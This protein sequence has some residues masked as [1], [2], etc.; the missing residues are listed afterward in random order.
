MEDL[1]DLLNEGRF[2]EA[3]KLAK[4][5]KDDDALRDVADHYAEAGKPDRAYEI[6]KEI[7][8]DYYHWDAMKSVA[9][10]YAD[11]GSFSKAYKVAKEVRDD[12]LCQEILDRA[13]EFYVDL[14]VQKGLAYAEMKDFDRVY[15]IL[16]KIIEVAERT[17]KTDLLVRAEDLCKKNEKVLEDVCRVIKEKIRKTDFKG[18][19]ADSSLGKT[20]VCSTAWM[21]IEQGKFEDAVRVLDEA[22]KHVDFNSIRDLWDLVNIGRLYARARAFEK[23]FEIADMIKEIKGKR[24]GR[25]YLSEYSHV[26]KE[27][28]VAYA[29]AKMFRESCRTIGKIK[30]DYVRVD[31]FV[32]AAKARIKHDYVEEAKDVLK[33]AFYLAEDIWYEHGLIDVAEVFAELGEHEW[34]R[35]ALE[36][37]CDYVKSKVEV[38]SIEGLWLSSSIWCDIA[39]V[40]AKNGDVD[41]AYE[42]AKGILFSGYRSEALEEVVKA[43]VKAGYLERAYKIA[44]DIVSVRHLAK[45]LGLIAREYAKENM[46]DKA[47]KVVD[48][49]DRL[50]LKVLE[51]IRRC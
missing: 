1:S 16:S 11:S 49:I 19:H 3:Y 8:D 23:A 18:D 15:K 45:C 12:T 24:Y 21:Y 39:K 14:L 47:L 36:I 29:E 13:Y 25:G 2:E 26:L 28:A 48:E 33:K 50:S 17:G 35:R 31:A 37:A 32:E 40:Y 20:K 41:R 38:G 46:F 30:N 22:C 51:E 4:K 9:E 6:A 43:C 42:I 7:E 10:A 44:K 34:A 5:M 27:I